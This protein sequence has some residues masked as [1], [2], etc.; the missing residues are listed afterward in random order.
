[1][2]TVYPYQVIKTDKEVNLRVVDD[3]ENTFIKCPFCKFYHTETKS[4][5]RGHNVASAWCQICDEWR[6]VA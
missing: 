5:S 4:C 6:Y 1:M 3:P 2:T